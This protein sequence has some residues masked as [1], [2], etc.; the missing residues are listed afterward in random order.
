MRL[1][2][3]PSPNC[4]PSAP[5]ITGYNTDV[6][7]IERVFHVQTE[8][9]GTANPYIETLIYMSGQVLAAKRTSYAELAKN[10]ADRR[11][12]GEL[13]ERQHRSMISSIHRGELD[14]KVRELFGDTTGSIRADALNKG[15]PE[16]TLDEV[17]LEYLTNEAQQEHLQLHMSEGAELM[18]GHRTE[19]TVRASSS[20]SGRPIE[21]ARVVVRMIS[22]ASQPRVLATG[23]TGSDGCV[24]LAAEIPEVAHGTSALIVTAD[25]AIGKAELKYL[26]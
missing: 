21:N 6:R 4:G 22:T 20:K 1:G 15:G 5:M 13:M 24:E 18:L 19:F 23:E 26:L 10:G 2:D 17:I 9:K 14:D 7:H 11:K 3:S 25:S 16:R 8:D 12:I